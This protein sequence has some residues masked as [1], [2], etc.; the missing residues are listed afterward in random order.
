MAAL[1]YAGKRY[2]VRTTT[3]RNPIDFRHR[4]VILH[5]SQQTSGPAQT[6]KQKRNDMNIRDEY[7]VDSNGRITSPGKFEGEPIFAPHF[8]NLALEG[9]SDSDNGSVY[10]FRFNFS[11]EQDAKLAQ[12]W[13]ELKKWLG[14]KRSLKLIEDSQGFVHCR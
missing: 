2:R 5:T 10:G 7:Q 12:E 14:R 8:W 3:E 4:R 9:F 6:R 1:R 11:N 13:P